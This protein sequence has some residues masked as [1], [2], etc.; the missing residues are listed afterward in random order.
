MTER[1]I[2]EEVEREIARQDEKWG[3]THDETHNVADWVS[4][5]VEHLGRAA[6]SVFSGSRDRA[7]RK[8]YRRQLIRVIALCVKAIQHYQTRV[9]SND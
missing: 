2:W 4:L 9:F 1:Q 7:A 8:K 6:Q 5:I 3:A